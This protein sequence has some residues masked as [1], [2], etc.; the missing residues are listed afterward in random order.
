MADCGTVV[1]VRSLE[2]RLL[3]PVEVLLD[4]QPVPLGGR[5]Q[6]ALLALLALRQGRPVT[7][8]ALASELWHGQ[9]PRGA[10]GTLRSYVSRLRHVLA[11]AAALTGGGSA[12]SLAATG[13]AVDAFRFERLVREGRAALGKGAVRRAAERFA[14]A[15]SLWRGDPLAGLG[16]E[17]LLRLESE[18]LAELR[19]DA[20]ELRIEADLALGGAGGLIGELETLVHDHPYREGFWRQLMIALYRAE[21]QADAL[22]A[23]RRAR[24]IFTSDLGLEPG[25]RLRELEQ[26][27]LRNQVPPPEPPE[28]RHNLPAPLTSF[29][30]RQP[31]LADV[32]QLLAASRLLTLTGPGGVGKTRLALEAAARVVADFPDG[33]FFCDL[34]PL[35]APGLVPRTVARTLGVRE[36]AQSEALPAL[37]ARLRTADLLLVLDNCEHVRDACAGLAQALLAS[38]PRLRVLATSREAL[39]VAGEVDYQVP[40]LALPSATADPEELSRSD[41]VSLFLARARAARPGLTASSGALRAAARVCTELDG[42]PLA[43]ELAAA[44]VKTLSFEEIAHRLADR[45]RFLVSS[46]PLVPARHRTLR[47]AMDWS[48]ALLDEEERKLLA[49]LAVFRG[50]FTLEAVAAVCLDGDDE[51]ALRLVGRLAGSSLV[52]V[53]EHDGVTRYRLLETIRE[54]AAGRLEAYAETGGLR[55]RH[56][57]WVLAFAEQSWQAQLATLDKWV[58]AMEREQGNIRAALGWTRDAGGPELLLRLVT[59]VWRFWWISGELTEGR[60]WLETALA[61]GTRS[62]PALRAE[63]LAGAAG[64]A[65]AQGDLD[66]ACAHAEELRALAPEGDGRSRHAALTVLGHVALARGE[67]QAARSRFERSREVARGHGLTADVAVATHNLGSVAFAEGDLPRAAGLYREARSLYQANADSYGVALCDLYLGLAAVEAGRYGEAAVSLGEALPVFRRMRFLQYAAQCLDGIAGVLRARGEAWEAVRLSGAAAA[68]REGMG[69][70]PSAGARCR[71]RE[72]AS[73]RAELGLDGFAA[74]W[75]EGMALPGHDAIALAEQA[76]TRQAR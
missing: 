2:I 56:A 45:F 6:A 58:E 42:L 61:L 43:I 29:V 55:G 73:A 68:L 76:V 3:G 69:E 26:A 64:L 15:L 53:E 1:G 74:A 37:A 27:I 47:E 5:R 17:G 49:R 4:G 72:L 30:G 36:H 60:T 50:G 44:R 10:A 70:A 39:G 54:Y 28:Q 16:S 20:A 12:Y 71:E 14:E 31:E 19:L 23:Y 65:W 52:L 35:S 21:R 8:D 40:P 7:V 22:A 13:E 46:R 34:A 25:E 11:G 9:P 24:A 38:C 41:A 67:Y 51:R 32:E 33:A 63:A 57:T 66:R 59:A 48:F 62:G 75:A 18:R